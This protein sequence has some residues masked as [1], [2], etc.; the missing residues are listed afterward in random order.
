MHQTWSTLSLLLGVTLAIASVVAVHL[1]SDRIQAQMRSTN[2]GARLGLTHAIEAPNLPESR[3]FDVRA[4]WR[5]GE[6]QAVKALVPM[7]EGD[8]RQGETTYHLVGFDLAGAPVA[9]GN[10]STTTKLL[11]E[12]AVLAHR[13]SG[14]QIGHELILGHHGEPVRVVGLYG[15][16]EVDGQTHWLIADIATAQEVL[17]QRGRLTRIGVALVQSD[18]TRL[19]N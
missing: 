3:Y 6:L 7:V 2:A 19:K 1:I 9:D 10:V 5:R 13:S 15:N 4:R 12:T 18:G 8:I 16:T 17:D 11:T 14:L